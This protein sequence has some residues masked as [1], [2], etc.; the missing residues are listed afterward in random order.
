MQTRE[1]LQYIIDHWPE[2][3]RHDGEE[4]GATDLKIDLPEEASLSSL[5]ALHLKIT[6]T[7]TISGN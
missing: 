7:E 5:P 4:V 6:R 3:A 1:P 2:A